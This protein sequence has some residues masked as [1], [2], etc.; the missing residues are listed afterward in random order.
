M[1]GGEVAFLVM[2]IAAALTF[3]AVVAWVSHRIDKRD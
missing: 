1:H 3:V 2:A